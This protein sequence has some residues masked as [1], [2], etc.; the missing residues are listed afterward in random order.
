MPAPGRSR[1]LPD[2]KPHLRRASSV[3]LLAFAIATISDCALRG[4]RTRKATRANRSCGELQELREQVRQLEAK[5][6]TR[7]AVIKADVAQTQRTTADVINDADRRSALLDAQ[8]FTAGWSNGKFLIQSEDGNFVLNPNFWLQVRY[9][10]NYRDEDAANPSTAGRRTESGFEIR[11]MKFLFEGNAFTPDLK[12][13]F[14][15]NTNRSTGNAFLE[16]RYV[17]YRFAERG[18]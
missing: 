16:D 13:R 17:S 10:L 8:G 12:Y 15:F 2:R 11:R 7:E 5:N 1:A 14:Q 6:A 18:P 9:D 4:P 3:A